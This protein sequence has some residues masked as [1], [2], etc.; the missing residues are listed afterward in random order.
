MPMPAEAAAV[1]TTSDSNPTEAGVEVEARQ[2]ISPPS[3]FHPLPSKK[4]IN[5]KKIT[6]MSTTNKTNTWK[7]ILQ[8]IVAAL[9]AIA[10]TLGVTSCMGANVYF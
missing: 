7:L 10:T 4:N 2:F 5:F 9:S 6:I 8:L 1:A 3:T